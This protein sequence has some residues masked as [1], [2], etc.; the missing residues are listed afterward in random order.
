[1]LIKIDANGAAVIPPGPYLEKQVEAAIEKAPAAF[2]G[3]DVLLIGRQVRTDRGIVDLL[4]LDRDG[5]TVIIELKRYDSPR[6]IVAQAISY[7]SHFRKAVKAEDLSR[8]AEGYFGDV[9]GDGVLQ[10]KLKERFGA[11]PKSLNK[12]QIVVLVAEHFPDG[13]LDDLEEVQDHICI[14]FSYFNADKGEEFFAVRRASEPDLAHAPSSSPGKAMTDFDPLFKNVIDKVK[15]TLPRPL[16]TFKNTQVRKRKESWV[17]FHWAGPDCHVGL[18]AKKKVDE[19]EISVYFSN[20]ASDPQVA[21]V[22]KSKASVLRAS[23]ALGPE[24]TLA[25]EEKLA[26]DKT[27]TEENAAQTVATFISTLKPLLGDRL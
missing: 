26:I 3:M 5:N 19:T 25:P 16:T 7:R 4:G 2:L 21:A 13:V 20:W 11:A 24:D 18:W 23:L 6:E 27:V 14:E 22:I 10:A 9:S 15:Q 1:M 8:I 17:R 12:R